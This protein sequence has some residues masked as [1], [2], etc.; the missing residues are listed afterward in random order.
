MNYL[1]ILK[2]ILRYGGF[3]LACYDAENE[4]YQTICKIG[5]GF[6]DEDLTKYLIFYP[7]SCVPGVHGFIDPPCKLFSC[8]HVHLRFIVHLC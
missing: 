4:E 6:T 5:T 1:C 3:L 8:V 2:T 7:S